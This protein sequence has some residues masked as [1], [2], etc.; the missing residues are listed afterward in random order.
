[1]KETL[2]KENFWDEMEQKYPKAMTH[3]K[4]WIDQYKS[5]HDWDKLFST[6]FFKFSEEKTTTVVGELAQSLIVAQA[7]KYHELPI[8]MQFGIFTEYM[9]SAP[10]GC[11]GIPTVLSV[12]RGWLEDVKFNIDW[13]LTEMETDL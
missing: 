4:Q 5:E 7:P 13:W 10:E 1:M 8:A 2:T 11:Y 3:F 9:L 12:G 6:G